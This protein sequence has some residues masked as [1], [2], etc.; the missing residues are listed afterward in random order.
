MFIAQVGTFLQ[1][2]GST[3]YDWYS[4]YPILILLCGIPLSWLYI[5]SVRNLTLA[6]NGEMWPNRIIGFGTG[7]IIFGFLSFFL[8][9]EPITFKTILCLSLSFIIIMIQIFMK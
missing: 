6:F 9:K 5:Q 7:A 4:K 2:Q 3:K 8:F 1:L